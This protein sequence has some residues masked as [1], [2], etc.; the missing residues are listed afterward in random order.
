MG[1]DEQLLAEKI[2]VIQN[3]WNDE[4]KDRKAPS[5]RIRNQSNVHIAREIQK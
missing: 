5:Q 3:T 2:Y 1:E 4:N